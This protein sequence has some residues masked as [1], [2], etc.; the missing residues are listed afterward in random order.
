MSEAPAPAVLKKTRSPA[1]IADTALP[2]AYCAYELCGRLT[3]AWPKAHITSPEQS[4]LPGPA[5]PY[6]YGAPTFDNAADTALGP[7]DD[8]G[9][10]VVGDPAPPRVRTAASG[11]PSTARPCAASKLRSA[12]R[13]CGPMTPSAVTPSL[14]CI[15][16]T[17]A[18]GI[19]DG[20]LV[21][22]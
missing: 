8:D 15:A 2:I 17:A 16:R 1:W 20:V 14:L 21:L 18:A 5:A 19:P 10:V 4:K 12:A 7:F 3:P 13:V 6:L 22:G 9:V 11:C